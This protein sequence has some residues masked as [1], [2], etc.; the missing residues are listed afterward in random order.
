MKHC[1]LPQDQV[2]GGARVIDVNMDEGMLLRLGCHG[3]IS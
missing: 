1:P 2:R 3:E